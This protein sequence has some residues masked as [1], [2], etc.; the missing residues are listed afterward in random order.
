M[1][2]DRSP[3]SEQ[4]WYRGTTSDQRRAFVAAALGWMLDSMDVMIYAVVLAYVMDD[5]GM[6]KETAG[7]LG[8]VG[9]L[10]SAAGGILFGIL[11]DRLGRVRALTISILTYA[12]FTAACGFAQSVSQLAVL[13]V[14][15][16][17]G[18]GGEWATGAALVAETWPAKHRGKALGLVQSFWA[19]G[20]AMAAVVAGVV[21]PAWGW[22][23][24][25]WI[26]ILPALVTFWIRRSVPE[27][28]IWTKSLATPRASSVGFRSIFVGRLGRLT[29]ALTLMQAGTM[30]AWWGFNTW[31]PAYLTLPLEQ[32]GFGMTA[33]AMAQFLVV[34][35]GGMW[36]GYVSYG[37][38]SDRLG[39][40]TTYVAYLITAACLL[41]LYGV[42]DS[43][44][45]LLALGP[46]VAF[47]ATGY[48][49]GMGPVTAEIYPT[50]IR[51]SSQGFIYNV[52]RAGGAI[53]PLT[54]GSVAHTGGFDVAFGVT[55]I[56][57]AFSALMWVFIPETKGRELE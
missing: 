30:F 52:G 53:A 14:F 47:F 49:S 29:L 10:A 50:R 12:V 21:V 35:Q 4:P 24:V 51:A 39:R 54:V 25:F 19:I 55:G 5:L 2:T 13:R 16:G 20:Q 27:P 6:S 22:R 15:V 18:M 17:L 31:I 28:A 1:S 57:F 9:L 43:R 44:L 36:L 46:V 11:A 26:G 23:P 40:K 34:M 56:A 33:G 7:L 45:L 42:I 32:G 38:I 37:F 8:S 3:S 48:F 41:P